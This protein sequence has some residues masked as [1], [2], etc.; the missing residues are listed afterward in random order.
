M[1]NITNT[2]AANGFDHFDCFHIGVMTLTCRRFEHYADIKNSKRLQFSS[3]NFIGGCR[4]F[5]RFRR[6]Y[7]VDWLGGK[8]TC[9]SPYAL[10]I[11]K[12]VRNVR[13]SAS[14]PSHHSSKPSINGLQMLSKNSGWQQGTSSEAAQDSQSRT[15]VDAHV[16]V[17]RNRCTAFEWNAQPARGC[18]SGPTVAPRC[19][20]QHGT[21]EPPADGSSPKNHRVFG[22][23]EQPRD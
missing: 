6:L 16:S 7:R 9:F 21:R 20:C 19:V 11:G 5:R 18:V 23:R 4:R 13:T 15:Q 2:N 8:R 17:C 12:H 14:Q 10:R 22:L 3:C 1:I